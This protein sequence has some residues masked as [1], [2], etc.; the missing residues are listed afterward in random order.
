M[1]PDVHITLASPADL[2]GIAALQRA[3]LKSAL[4]ALEI[5]EQGFV[6]LVHTLDMLERMHELAPSV[7]AKA[8]DEVVGYALTMVPEARPL[9]PALEP[10][11]ETL[12]TARIR[13]QSIENVRFYVMGQVCV[14]RAFRGGGV[15]AA[16]YAEHDARFGDRFDWI[17]TELSA[18]N[19][20]SLRAHEKVGFE[21][22]ASY[23]HG[24]DEWLVIARALRAQPR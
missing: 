7:V 1:P 2:R 17:V 14:A 23:G 18:T 11:F 12:A 22:L 4:S 9:V 3:N 21:R 10:M 15:F 20:R 8:G 5:R 24:R 16:L 6:T 19:T 13:G